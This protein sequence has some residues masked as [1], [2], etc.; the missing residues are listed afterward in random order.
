MVQALRVATPGNGDRHYNYLIVFTLQ[1]PGAQQQLSSLIITI[2]DQIRRPEQIP[3][4]ARSIQAQFKAT[5][6]QSGAALVGATP[7]VQVLSF[8]VIE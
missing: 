2:P 5:D 7:L 3:A 1:M 4:I 8:Q 6:K